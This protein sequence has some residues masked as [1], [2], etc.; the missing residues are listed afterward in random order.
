MSG[1]SLPPPVVVQDESTLDHLAATLLAQPCIAVDT[2]S[3]SL[4]A[5]QEQVCLIQFSTR[6]TDYLVDTLALDDLS[7]LEPLFRDPAIEK[8]LHGA[9]YDLLCMGRDFGFHFANLFDTRVAS[10]TL[11]WERSGLGD[12]L[13]HAFGLQISKRFQ[14]ANWGARPLKQELLD[15]ARLDTHY[16]LE[17]RDRLAEELERAGR[18]HEA[19]ELCLRMTQVPPRE[20]GFDPQGYFRISKSKELR[21]AQ[22]AVLRELYLLR[23]RLARR[24]NRPPF[25]VL[26][27]SELVAIAREMPGVEA[28]LKRLGRLSPRQ[29]KRFGR[30][31][32]QAVDRGRSAP[33]P[34][35]P[36]RS[37]IDEAVE[38]R[39]DALRKWRKQVALKRHVE[40]DIILPRDVLLEIAAE[41][42]RDSQTLHRIL[43]PLEWRFQKYHA[44]ILRILHDP[45]TRN[46]G[47]T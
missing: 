36:R 20:N 30:D 8:V 27:D 12:L 4:Y 46:R 7:P 17:L 35:R 41:N 6:D 19:Q 23:D 34:R 25:K 42:P 31:L 11:G 9:E 32:L 39:F 38:A 47:K 2:E 16:L 37:R 13:E 1:P 15:Y 24:L 40:S 18:R 28:E 33:A 44:D 43:E 3:N 14:R 29:I 10:R 21:G 5:Y 45:P 26:G 22:L